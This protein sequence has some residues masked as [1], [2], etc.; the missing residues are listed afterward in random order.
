ME[1]WSN[2]TGKASISAALMILVLTAPVVGAQPTCT[3]P[4]L[5]EQEIAAI[6]AQQRATRT[7]MP[8]AFESSTAVLRRKGC[9]YE[10]IE[11]ADPPR[12]GATFVFTLNQH[13][14]IVDVFYGH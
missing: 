13:G 6:I 2:M 14:V 11:S 12:P 10:Y 5:S 3:E 1:V 9:H 4:E 8:P 7:D